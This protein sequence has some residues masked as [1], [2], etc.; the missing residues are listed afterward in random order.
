MESDLKIYF[1]G[2]G[3]LKRERALFE[4]GASRLHSYYLI[5]S[6][7]MSF[8]AKECYENLLCWRSRRGSRS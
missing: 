4:F 3:G 5:V 1:A 8:D 7:E 6:E 2:V